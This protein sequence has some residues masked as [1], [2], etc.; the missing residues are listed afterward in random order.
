MELIVIIIYKLSCVIFQ[1]LPARRAVSR[2]RDPG[3]RQRQPGPAET[4]E[5]P[6]GPHRLSESKQ[7]EKL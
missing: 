6:P 7:E 2:G 3:V 1:R 4:D 5:R